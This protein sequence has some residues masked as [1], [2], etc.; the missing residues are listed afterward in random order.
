MSIRI[1]RIILMTILGFKIQSL[2][3]LESASFVLYRTEQRTIE[4]GIYYL[5]SCMFIPLFNL[6]RQL[7][8]PKL[9]LHFLLHGCRFSETLTI[10]EIVSYASGSARRKSDRISRCERTANRE[11]VSINILDDSII[12]RCDYV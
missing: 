5:S 4:M 3:N 11:Y 10:M 2:K 12:W 6:S 7:V 1:G 8:H 9:W